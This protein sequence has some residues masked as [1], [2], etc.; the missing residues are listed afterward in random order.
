MQK[1]LPFHN[2]GKYEQPLCTQ[3]YCYKAQ[4]WPECAPWTAISSHIYILFVK[5]FLIVMLS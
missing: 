5:L 3:Y 4:N 1:F 2:H